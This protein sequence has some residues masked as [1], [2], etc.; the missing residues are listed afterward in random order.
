MEIWQ[1]KSFRAVASALHFTR[2]SEALNLSQSAVSH[3]IKALEEELGESLFV[4]YKKGVELTPHGEIA[5]RYANEVL[6]QVE[7][8]KREIRELEVADKQVVRLSSN[9]A[10]LQNPFLELRRGFQKSHPEIEVYYSPA[11]GSNDALEKIRSGVCDVAV[12]VTREKTEGL[13]VYPYGEFRMI[14]VVGSRHRFA[15][16]PQRFSL[17][18]LENDEW[19]L[20][21]KKTRLRQA[22][23]KAF[24]R[25]G[26]VP[27]NRYES[28]D[29]GV[30]REL[31]VSGLGVGFLPG[32]GIHSELKKEKLFE[33]DLGFSVTMPVYIVTGKDRESALIDKFMAFLVRKSF[34]GIEMRKTATSK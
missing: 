4:R 23:D 16:V 6:D 5:L 27:G 25:N 12:T 10:S 13:Q 19:L 11:N 3:Q 21:D 18:D 8:M 29:G 33:L 9:A 26:F 2:A 22:I 32:W 28:R 17:K 7:L 24:E 30:I 15:A 34:D 20:F 1:L 31:I 14:P